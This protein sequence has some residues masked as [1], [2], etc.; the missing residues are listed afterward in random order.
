[1]GHFKCSS[2]LIKP[3]NAW[4]DAQKSHCGCTHSWM[5]V[6]GRMWPRWGGLKEKDRRVKI[7]MAH[8]G[9]FVL[10]FFSFIFFFFH[11]FSCQHC[12]CLWLNMFLTLIKA[13]R[14]NSLGE[15]S[16]SSISH[17]DRGHVCFLFLSLLSV[18]AYPNST[19][20]Y[21]VILRQCSLYQWFTI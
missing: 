12:L 21:E 3:G 16:I 2:C 6:N 4:E 14:D 20:S 15:F 17:F 18:V 10:I 8:V 9:D 7:C 19:M 5:K 1:M 11:P 13:K